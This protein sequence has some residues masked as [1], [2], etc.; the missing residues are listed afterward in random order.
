M[1]PLKQ[2]GP[3]RSRRPIYR[4]ADGKRVPSVTTVLNVIGKDY[5]VRWANRLGLQ[6]INSEEF[7]AEAAGAGTVV[8]AAIEADLKGE[9]MDPALIAEFSDAERTAGRVAWAAYRAWRGQHDLEPLLMEQSLV[10]E[11]MRVGGTVDL[12][13]RVDGRHAVIDF[14]TSARVNE[15][16]V[17]QLAAYR[18]LLEEHGHPVDE[19]R[20]VLIPR[21]VLTLEHEGERVLTDTQHALDVFHAARALYE[22]Q[23]VMEATQ[24]KDREARA[25]AVR[26]GI[27][28]GTNELFERMKR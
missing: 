11:R 27:E 4:T 28:Q 7:V 8:H 5:L 12:Y 14:K 16:H 2:Q 23:R 19:V 15:S 20:V 13:A 17:V 10:S 25:K 3:L 21:E 24:R 26:E 1:S 18:A 9:A 6:G 22:A